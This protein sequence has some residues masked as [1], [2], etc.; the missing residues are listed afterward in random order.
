[1]IVPYSAASFGPPQFCFDT[2]EDTTVVLFFIPQSCRVSYRSLQ[3]A[4]NR[5]LAC[6]HS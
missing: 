2:V 5:S 6:P 3:R 4:G 1:L